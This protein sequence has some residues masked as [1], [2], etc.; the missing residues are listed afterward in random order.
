[1]ASALKIK[2]LT[3]TADQ[4]CFFN[5]L[6]SLSVKNLYVLPKINTEILVAGEG[7]FPV[8]EISIQLFTYSFYSSQ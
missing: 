5:S 7:F 1:M 6:W 4:F 3:L 8:V 2:C